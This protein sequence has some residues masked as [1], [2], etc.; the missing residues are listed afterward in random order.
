MTELSFL[1]AASPLKHTWIVCSWA[2]YS[3]FRSI[4]KYICQIRAS[5]VMDTSIMDT[6]SMNTCILRNGYTLVR[7]TV[8]KVHGEKICITS[9]WNKYRYQELMSGSHFL[10]EMQRKTFSLKYRKGRFCGSLSGH[11]ALLQKQR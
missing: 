1:L 5:C 9:F 11:E 10:S 8:Y 3:V 6:C 4:R 7:R 2:T